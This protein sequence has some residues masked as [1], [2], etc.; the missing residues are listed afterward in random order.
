MLVLGTVSVR[1]L[2]D[3]SGA[4]ESVRE[5]DLMLVCRLG[6]IAEVRMCLRST[7]VFIAFQRHD[8]RWLTV[9]ISQVG[10]KWPPS[11][12]PHRCQ[13]HPR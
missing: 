4:F 5:C 13:R 3:S 2:G 7:Y 10:L 12:K 11:L 8:A 1:V 6:D 9:Y